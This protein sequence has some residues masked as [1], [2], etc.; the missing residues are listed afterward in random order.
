[1][2]LMSYLEVVEAKQEIV[3]VG[4]NTARVRP[5]PHTLSTLL[6]GMAT[7]RPGL[8]AVAPRASF[9]PLTL[10][11]C[12]RGFLMYS[13]CSFQTLCAPSDI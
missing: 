12:A 9:S 2:F 8:S 6:L 4:V 3:I 5:H 11:P 13:Q 1:M 10:T 7:E